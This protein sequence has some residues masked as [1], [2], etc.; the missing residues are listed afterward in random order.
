MTDSMVRQSR[1]PSN[2]FVCLY[3][4]HT[5]RSYNYQHPNHWSSS[6]DGCTDA[7]W[8]LLGY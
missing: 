6:F 1:G 4:K 7:S 8:D 2:Q 5:R 3:K